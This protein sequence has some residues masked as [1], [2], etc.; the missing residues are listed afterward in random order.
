MTF[1]EFC[2]RFRSLLS[3]TMSEAE[4][5]SVTFALFQTGQWTNPHPPHQQTQCVWF[6]MSRCEWKTL[7]VIQWY[8]SIAIW[9]E[10]FVSFPSKQLCK[11]HFATLQT[12][13]EPETNATETNDTYS[14]TWCTSILRFF[15][16]LIYL[17]F[18]LERDLRHRP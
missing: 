11:V 7:S 16:Y 10:L 14:F 12:P 3:I 2:S 6:E 15:N 4:E 9:M 18:N 13:I 17:L 5:Y 8:L 1:Y